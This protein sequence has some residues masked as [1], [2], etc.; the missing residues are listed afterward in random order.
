MVMADLVARGLQRSA[1]PCRI[2]QAGIEKG[3]G[4]ASF[5]AFE[6]T[7]SLR[8]EG[9]IP[10]RLSR[11]PAPSRAHAREMGTVADRYLAALAALERS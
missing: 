4:I 1:A 7:L 9:S 11:E 6:A 8:V 10:S 5:R 2:L 3:T